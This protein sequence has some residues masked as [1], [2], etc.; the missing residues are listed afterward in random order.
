MNLTQA[1]LSA[2][3]CTEPLITWTINLVYQPGLT[4]SQGTES[5][6]CSKAVTYQPVYLGNVP[7]PNK[8]ISFPGLQIWK[9][10]QVP[11]LEANTFTP[12]ELYKI[13]CPW[14]LYQKEFHR[15]AKGRNQ[16]HMKTSNSLLAAT[17]S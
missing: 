2:F 3:G 4:R 15:D 1:N 8:K 17:G 5:W 9:E 12:L 7:S 14:Y 16:F 11:N 13:Q 10:V 6:P